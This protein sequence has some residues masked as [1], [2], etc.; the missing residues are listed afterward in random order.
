VIRGIFEWEFGHRMAF[1]NT[2][3]IERW[4]HRLHPGNRLGTFSPHKKKKLIYPT[5]IHLAARMVSEK[6][7]VPLIY[8]Y[9]LSCKYIKSQKGKEV[10]SPTPTHRST[11]LSTSCSLKPL[12]QNDMAPCQHGGRV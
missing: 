6:K 7:V 12:S 8:T 5:T 3:L 2:F 10:I 11:P 1:D 9:Q 4:E